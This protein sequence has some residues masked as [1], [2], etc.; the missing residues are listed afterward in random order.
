MS[1][2]RVL[3][4][5]IFLLPPVV[6]FLACAMVLMRGAESVKPAPSTCNM[7]RYS[8]WLSLRYTGNLQNDPIFWRYQTQAQFRLF[9][10]LALQIAYSM[11]RQRMKALITFKAGRIGPIDDQTT[12]DLMCS[13]YCLENDAI[14]QS[15]MAYSG[16]NCLELSTQPGES[17]YFTAGDWCRHNTGR[18]QCDILGFCGIWNCKLED[19]MCP[20]YEY[21]KRDI[22][23][24]GP[25]S[26]VS[27]A[28][29]SWQKAS[30]SAALLVTAAAVLL[31]F[32]LQ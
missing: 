18:M 29:G 22:E 5:T 25:G 31:H 24:R 14:H 27:A 1:I 15:A 26:C 8:E 17:A 3:P 2:R 13:P 32:L 6:L 7:T 20:R 28:P 16:C 4:S 10:Q 30:S 19:Y 21:N 23:F 12:Y 11:C 9:N